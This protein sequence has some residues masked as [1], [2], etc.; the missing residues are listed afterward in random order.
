MSFNPTNEVTATIAPVGQWARNL[1]TGQF[2]CSASLLDFLEVSTPEEAD[3]IITSLERVHPEDHHKVQSF[4]DHLHSRA[5]LLD[6]RIDASVL[7]RYMAPGSDPIWLQRNATAYISDGCS[8]VQDSLI[9]IDNETAAC[10]ILEVAL[11]SQ[12]QLNFRLKQASE[13]AQ[14]GFY[15]LD[16]EAQEFLFVDDIALRI[17]GLSDLPKEEV[18]IA[19]FFGRVPESSQEFVANHLIEAGETGVTKHIEYALNELDGKVV[20]V[21]CS[22]GRAYN[23]KGRSYLYGFVQDI[24]VYKEQ[25]LGLRKALDEL[26][27]QSDRQRQ[28]FAVIGHELRT[29][30]AS[31]KMMLDEQ[32]SH[33][34]HSLYQSSIYETLQHVINVMDDLKAVARPE[35]AIKEQMVVDRP[36]L[37]VESALRSQQMNL[38]SAGI[39]VHLQI[40]DECFQLFEMSTQAFRQIVINL[41]KNAAVH[42]GA[43]D[44]WISLECSSASSDFRRHFVLRVEDNG[45][46]I[47]PEHRER[48]FD[49]F[50]RVDEKRDGAGLGLS[51][52]GDLAKGMNGSLG[53]Y[54]R[55]SQGSRFEFTFELNR[56]AQC[57]SEDKD[58]DKVG[59]VF[60]D[61][62]VLIAEDNPTIRLL[63]V[64]LLESLGSVVVAAENGSLALDLFEANKFDMVFTDIFMPVMNGYELTAELRNRGFDGPVFGVTAATVGDEAALLLDHGATAVLSK[65]LDGKKLRQLL[66]LDA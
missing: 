15:E 65:P 18:S 60:K 12:M 36:G 46:G 7:F 56:S 32:K 48:L 52:S 45:C 31:I 43:T 39:D 9:K 8:F 13:K 41:L 58:T 35:T 30:L 66:S 11:E 17:Y 54:E 29:P 44:V 16:M 25:E 62:C 42:S 1:T 49:P 14:L 21:S 26:N 59:I 2:D 24:T 5:V 22:A 37:I 55:G 64:K 3:E 38:S 10:E 63:S 4:I 34:D 57:E 27:A 50:Y 6:Q 51:I 19:H 53:F 61:K 40:A 28:M 20:W 47:P 33:N 23:T